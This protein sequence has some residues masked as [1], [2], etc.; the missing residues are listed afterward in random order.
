MLK[1]HFYF[2]NLMQG[3]QLHTDKQ[4]RYKDF[5]L[6]TKIGRDKNIRKPIYNLFITLCAALFLTL[7]G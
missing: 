4:F 6:F 3:E 5:S 7:Q 1:E 2:V